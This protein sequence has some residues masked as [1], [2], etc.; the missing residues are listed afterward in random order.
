MLDW[1]LFNMS[2]ENF[3][4]CISELRTHNKDFSNLTFI[5][6]C[7]IVAFGKNVVTLQAESKWKMKSEK[8]KNTSHTFLVMAILEN[9]NLYFS[10]F[11][12]HFSFKQVPCSSAASPYQI[13]CKS[14]SG[15]GDWRATMDGDYE[16][17]RGL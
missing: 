14:H 8:W 1:V 16:S 3:L 7:Y 11:I 2:S 15:M 4:L 10:F 12:V 5:C 6:S 17:Q 9:A 13:R